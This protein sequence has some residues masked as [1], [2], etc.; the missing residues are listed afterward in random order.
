MLIAACR[1]TCSELRTDTL[2]ETHVPPARVSLARYVYQAL[3]TEA[4]HVR[5]LD[6][7]I[8]RVFDGSAKT[9]S[10]LAP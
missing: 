5:C 8:Q 2:A 3:S 1:S 10:R 6:K 7:M 9:F 4:S